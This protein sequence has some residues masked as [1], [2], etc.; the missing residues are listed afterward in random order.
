VAVKEEV[1]LEVKEQ[2]L[3]ATLDPLERETVD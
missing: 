1:V 2:M 3:A